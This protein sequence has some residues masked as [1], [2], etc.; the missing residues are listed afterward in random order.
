MFSGG[1]QPDWRRAKAQRIDAELRGIG[2]G[3]GRLR[4]ALGEALETM[5]R[6]QGHHALGFSSIEAYARERC[7][8]GTGRVR[9]LRAVARRLAELPRLKDA[10]EEG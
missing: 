3:D 2:R 4:L 9:E 10:L 7:G 1:N 6:T 5:L 8:L